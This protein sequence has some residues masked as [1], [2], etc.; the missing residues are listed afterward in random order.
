[1]KY[2]LPKEKPKKETVS[3]VMFRLPIELVEPF[4]RALKESN[5]LAQMLVES[6]VSYCLEE[7]GFIK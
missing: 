4:N 2:Q 7:S 1:M 5:L 3:S 6:M